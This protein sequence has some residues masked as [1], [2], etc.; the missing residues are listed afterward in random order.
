MAQPWRGSSS[1]STGQEQQLGIVQHAH[2][3]RSRRT[4]AAAAA[5][6]SIGAVAEALGRMPPLLPVS[7]TWG[8]WSALVAAGAFGMW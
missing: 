7:G 2:S 6:F 8:V 1:S 4:Q 3:G 5:S